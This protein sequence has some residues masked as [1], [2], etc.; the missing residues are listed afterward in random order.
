MDGFSLIS[1]RSLRLHFVPHVTVTLVDTK[2]ATPEELHDEKW[3]R[4]L[5][6]LLEA[7]RGGDI[8]GGDVCGTVGD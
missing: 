2:A 1:S 5:V 8:G 4:L 3:L 7:C 6:D